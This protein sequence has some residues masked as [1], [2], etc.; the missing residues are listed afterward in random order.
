MCQVL[1]H[2]KKK[3]QKIQISPLN[4]CNSRQSFSNFLESDKK[5]RRRKK[6]WESFYKSFR[7]W[8][9]RLENEFVCCFLLL[10]MFMFVWGWFSSSSLFFFLLLLYSISIRHSSILIHHLIRHFRVF[11]I[12]D[13]NY[14]TLIALLTDSWINRMEIKMK[15]CWFC[16][17]YSTRLNE[18]TWAWEKHRKK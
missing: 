2:E 16:F 3:I 14:F 17:I 8:G 13:F 5:E 6:S 4:K 7:W 15:L 11:H 12:I 9:F 10:F 1:T 18:C